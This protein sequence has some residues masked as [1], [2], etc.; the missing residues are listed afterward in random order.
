MKAFTVW[1][2]SLWA[3][4]EASCERDLKWNRRQ[5]QLVEALY[6]RKYAGRPLAWLRAELRI[7]YAGLVLTWRGFPRP[8]RLMALCT[9]A[10]M[11]GIAA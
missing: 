3:A 8:I 2:V 11:F 4:C 10:A 7:L 5:V 1:L 6:R 9:Y